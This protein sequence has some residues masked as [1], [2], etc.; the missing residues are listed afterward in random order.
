MTVAFARPEDR[1]VALV[2]MVEHEPG[3]EEI[4]T[5]VE[6]SGFRVEEHHEAGTALEAIEYGA[7]A[8]VVHGFDLPDMDG[9]TFHTAVGKRAGGREIPTLAVLSRG[10]K[11]DAQFGEQTGITHYLSRPFDQAAM[12][13]RLREMVPGI[14]PDESE[15]AEPEPPEAAL[16]P[17]GE[18]PQMVQ[19]TASAEPA[20][21]TGPTRA[22]PEREAASIDF[23]VRLIGLGEWGVRG[24][25][26]VAERGLEARAVDAEAAVDRA[27]LDAA[28]R[29]RIEVPGRAGAE[30]WATGARALASDETL[31]AALAEDLS[32]ADLLVVAANVGVGAGVLLATL[33]KRVA[34]IAPDAGRL[35]IVRLPGL[36]SGPEERALALVVLNAVLQ[37]P[38]TSVL[39]VQPGEGSTV[40]GPA[41]SDPHAPFRRLLEL[42]RDA[43]GAGGEGARA[44]RGTAMAKFLA[45]PG[46][47]GWRELD[48]A[49]EDCASSAG[50]WHEKLVDG[51]VRWQPTGF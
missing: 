15:E 11:P 13:S 47:I 51:V 37:G 43:S 2:V 49:R 14:G 41:E 25:E 20:R 26:L 12:R 48:L 7:P 42:W 31:A 28:S 4:V 9:A 10:V 40:H 45:T 22:E 24:A 27:R 1:P 33:L 39:L 46:F 44:V 34:G 19:Q 29:H 36:R 32:D 16:G 8:L 23:R 17:H 50:A 3:R 21:E 6:G 5:A 38:D 30:D 18:E 35:A